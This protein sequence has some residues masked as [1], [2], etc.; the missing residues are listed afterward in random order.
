MLLIRETDIYMI[1]GNDDSRTF[2]MTRFSD[3][4]SLVMP[5]KS[6]QYHI[7]RNWYATAAEADINSEIGYLYTL[8]FG[9]VNEAVM[10]S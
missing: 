1:E 7:N 9:D 2:K 6:R 3:E 5:I 10:V 4:Q 8:R